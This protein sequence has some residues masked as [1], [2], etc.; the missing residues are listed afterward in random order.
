MAQ[1]E[2]RVSIREYARS[3]GVSDTAVRKAIKS[4]KIKGGYDEQSKKI[5]T[6]IADREWGD[7]IIQPSQTGSQTSPAKEEKSKEP[8]EGEPV[9]NG[10]SIFIDKDETYAEALRKDLIIKANLN[11]LKLRMKEGEVV[12]KSKVYK[13]LFAFGKQIRLRFQSIPDRIIDDV[14]AAPGRNEAHMIVFN[15]ISDVLEELT[16]IGEDELKF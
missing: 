2:K 3:K 15:A 10:D 13:E 1:T 9:I 5:I 4:G 8:G 7:T 11:A 14:L 6:E 16:G 12:E